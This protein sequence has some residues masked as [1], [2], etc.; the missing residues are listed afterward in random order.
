MV[1]WGY[2]EFRQAYEETGEDDHVETICRHFCDYFMRC[3]FRDKSG[4]VVA[5][6]YQVGDGSV[7]HEYWQ[8]P[9]I[10]AM[11]RPAFFATSELPTT[12]DVSEAAAALACIKFHHLWIFCEATNQ[13]NFIHLLSPFA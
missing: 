13:D 11:G 5:F 8:S 9:E 2:Y 3:T 10:D 1:S 7:D 6:C 12:D 4:D